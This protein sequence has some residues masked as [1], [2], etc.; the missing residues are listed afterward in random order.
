MKITQ[1]NQ[2]VAHN[3]SLLPALHIA[4]AQ[5]PGVVPM[6]DYLIQHQAGKQFFHK[7]VYQPV[8]GQI[9]LLELPGLGL[10]LDKAKV[11]DRREIGRPL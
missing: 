10:V 2:V 9:T 11:N 5:S 8:H 7:P 3:L 1:V 4:T 6:V